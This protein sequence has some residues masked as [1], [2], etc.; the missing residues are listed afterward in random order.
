MN[1]AWFNILRNDK[2][3]GSVFAIPDD[4]VDPRIINM[5]KHYKTASKL[6]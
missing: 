2:I 3:P 6:K 4:K 1:H 5:L